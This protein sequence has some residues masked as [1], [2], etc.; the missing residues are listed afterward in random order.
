DGLDRLWYGHDRADRVRRDRL[1]CG[2]LPRVRTGCRDAHDQQCRRR[3]HLRAGRE[4]PGGGLRLST[5]HAVMGPVPSLPGTLREPPV[6]S[7]AGD[8]GCPWSTPGLSRSGGARCERAVDTATDT[9]AE[10]RSAATT[11]ACARRRLG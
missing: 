11:A 9:D 2:E 6:R 3:G 1:G 7:L 8:A 10:P 5:M 4:L